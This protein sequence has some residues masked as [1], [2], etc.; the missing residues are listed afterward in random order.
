MN[1]CSSSS[2]NSFAIHLCA[3]WAKKKFFRANFL[4]RFPAASSRK[5]IAFFMTF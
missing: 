2:W 1:L 5:T 3:V 4:L